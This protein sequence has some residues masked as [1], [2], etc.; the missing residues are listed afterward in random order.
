MTTR[1][2][3]WYTST[4]RCFQE[5]VT[6]CGWR[7]QSV[8]TSTSHQGDPQDGHHLTSRRS[9]RRLRKLSFASFLA[10]AV[11]RCDCQVKVLV[12]GNALHNQQAMS[13]LNKGEHCNLSGSIKL[14]MLM[15]LVTLELPW[16]LLKKK[17]RT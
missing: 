11:R 9:A 16:I 4:T 6:E 14:K 17:T 1:L 8:D 13:L 15:M 10:W 7:L 12:V 3:Q 5:G 2:I